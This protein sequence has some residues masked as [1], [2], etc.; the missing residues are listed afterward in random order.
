MFYFFSLRSG[1]KKIITEE[2]T[3]RMQPIANQTQNRLPIRL[4][5]SPD[6]NGKLKMAVSP[7]VTS[8]KNPIFKREI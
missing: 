4:A 7:S 5:K 1:K 2:I 6:I 8:N 3:G